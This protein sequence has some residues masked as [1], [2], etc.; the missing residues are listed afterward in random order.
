MSSKPKFRA[1]CAGIAVVVASVVV[2]FY[3]TG[4]RVSI[5]AASFGPPTAMADLKEPAKRD[6][7]AKDP[8]PKQPES[9]ETAAEEPATAPAGESE[10]RS[11]EAVIPS[12][13]LSESQRASVK[14]E[15]VGEHV[16]PIEKSA[17]GSIDFNEDMSVQVFT[18][19]QGRIINLFAKVGDDVQQGQTLFTIDSP[20]LL[21]AESMLIAAAG[22]LELTTK[23]LARASDV[24]LNP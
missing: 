18:P 9:K 19:Y 2:A 3:L 21:Q 22:V 5:T 23:N 7:G 1:F 13:A 14:V 10:K 4:V 12:V 11:A 20:D 17:V 16:F 15:A 24:Q 6:Y 8:P